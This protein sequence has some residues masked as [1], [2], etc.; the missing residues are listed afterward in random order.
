ML[1]RLG[2]ALILACLGWG[3]PAWAVQPADYLAELRVQARAQA[4][5]QSPQ[6]HA[7]L[8]Y[9]RQPLTRQLRSLADD[10]DFFTAPTGKTDPQAELDATLAAFFGT[11]SFKAEQ[12]AQCRFRARYEWLREQLRF[13]PARLPP[14]PCPRFDAWRAGIQSD[15]ISLVYPAAYIDSPASMY[16]H[17]L[18]RLD[19]QDGPDRQPLLAYSI[20]YAADAGDASSDPFYEFKGLVG[21][22]PGAFTNAPYYQ[23]IRDY[24]HLEDRDIWEYSLNLRPDELQRLVAHTWELGHTRFDYWF[25]DEN[26]AYHLL[27]LL[28]VARPSLALTDHYTWWAIPG[29]TVRTVTDVPGLISGRTYRPS[30][31]TQL[32]AR[33]QALAAPERDSARQL[34]QGHLAPKDPGGHRRHRARPHSGAGRAL[35]GLVGGSARDRQRRS[36]GTAHGAVGCASPVATAG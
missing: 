2:G 23:R 10:A 34:S 6:W 15:R 22:Y 31:G 20:S 30:N 4:L 1:K 35:G 24:T 11:Q 26:C 25:F 28:D 13:D 21:A 36:P 3:A 8:H 9:K 27:S 19:P 32:R 5:A 17:T 33:A 29:D 12:T 16:G 18:L 14:Q 7:L